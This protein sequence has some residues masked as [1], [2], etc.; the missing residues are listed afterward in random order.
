MQASRRT[1]LQLQTNEGRNLARIIHD[2]TVCGGKLFRVGRLALSYPKRRASLRS[3]PWAGNGCPLRV[4]GVRAFVR[5]FQAFPRGTSADTKRASWTRSVALSDA[6]RGRHHPGVGFRVFGSG[7]VPDAENAHGRQ[8]AAENRRTSGGV[9]LRCD[10]E[11]V[12]GGIMVVAVRKD[13]R[14]LRTRIDEDGSCQ[15]FRSAFPLAGSWPV[16]G[17]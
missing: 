1:D 2:R 16:A 11:I 6:K 15:V 13:A 9:Q 5:R 14:G 12:E 4:C 3:W 8:V 10:R 17:R 7:D